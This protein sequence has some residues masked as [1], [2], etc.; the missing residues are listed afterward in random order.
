MI[1]YALFSRTLED[2]VSLLDPF[3]HTKQDWEKIKNFDFRR[4]QSAPE[5]LTIEETFCT[6]VTVGEKYLEKENFKKVLKKIDEI[7]RIIR[8]GINDK[9]IK[10]CM[11]GFRLILVGHS[12]VFRIQSDFMLFSNYMNRIPLAVFLEDEIGNSYIYKYKNI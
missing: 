5:R 10:Q 4:E 12:N 11:Q 2:N 1:T 7:R 9:C 6:L 3:T 8:F